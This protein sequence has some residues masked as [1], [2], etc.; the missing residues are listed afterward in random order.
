MT[1]A[2][3]VD[4]RYLIAVVSDDSISTFADASSATMGR[5][6]ELFED[7]NT[8]ENFCDA[9]DGYFL[10]IPAVPFLSNVERIILVN[11]VEFRHVAFAELENK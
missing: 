3:K 4:H 11:F 6:M 1:S 2:M 7:T 8:V 10:N 5:V 9:Y